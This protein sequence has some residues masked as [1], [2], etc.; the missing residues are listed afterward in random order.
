MGLFQV[1]WK[2][3]SFKDSFEKFCITLTVGSK[4]ILSVLLEILFVVDDFLGQSFKFLSNFL[5]LS[6]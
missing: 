3:A 4:L 1:I 6:L 2:C 5:L